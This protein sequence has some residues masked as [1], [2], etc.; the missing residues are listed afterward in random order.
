MKNEIVHHVVILG[1][2]RSGTSIF[3]ELFEHLSPY[4]YFSEPPFAEVVQ[5]D[6]TRPIAVKVPKEST[7]YPTTPG[8][9]FPLSVLCAQI[10]KPISFFWIVRH[11]LDAVCSLR[12]GISKNWGHHPKPPD[13]RA[14]LGKPLIERCAYHW[15]YINS[16]GYDKVRSLAKL[17]HF[18][19]M[20]QSP[21]HF[22]KRICKEVDLD[23]NQ[24]ESAIAEW[25]C[26]VQNTNNEHFIEAKTSRNYSRA[27]HQTR[28]DRWKEN[29]SPEEI[30]RVIPIV[31]DTA[32]QFGYR[33]DQIQDP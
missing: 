33:L 28:I 10:P 15:N 5:L 12:V 11:P 2:G 8:L 19:S 29:L 26:R 7:N 32:E 20:I 6:F 1:C 23:I 31:K 27:D 24:N 21:R 14:W 30:Q 17:K 25:A 9:S 18:E 13:W 3:G 22:A 16:L 4:T